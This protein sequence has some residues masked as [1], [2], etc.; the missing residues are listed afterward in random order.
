[1]R[2]DDFKFKHITMQF[3]NF[4]GWKSLYVVY[5]NFVAIDGCQLDFCISESMNRVD[6]KYVH[7]AN[8]YSK[9]IQ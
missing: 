4:L 7:K 9:F 3:I 5:L 1:M 2:K 8:K 6:V